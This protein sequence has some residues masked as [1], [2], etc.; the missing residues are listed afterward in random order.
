M[1]ATTLQARAASGSSSSVRAA[2]SSR[3]S[4]F[5]T[6]AVLRP[7][8]PSPPPSSKRFVPALVPSKSRP[9]VS[10]VDGGVVVG[11]RVRAECGREKEGKRENQA[12]TAICA[13]LV[14]HGGILSSSFPRRIPIAASS[15]SPFSNSLHS[16]DVVRRG[17]FGLGLPELAVIAGVAALI[18]G[19]RKK[20]ATQR[21]KKKT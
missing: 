4:T 13:A 19:K 1:Q 21:K 6:V 2:S 9:L 7:A 16:Q 14:R 12:K 10:S 18:F 17:L 15:L 5:T 11:A 20:T 3:R 8:A